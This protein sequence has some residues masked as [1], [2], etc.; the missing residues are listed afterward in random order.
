MLYST[1]SKLSKTVLIFSLV[2]LGKVSIAALSDIKFGQYQIADSQWNTSAC[3]NTTT[4]Q[5]YSK[6]PGTAYKIP[7]WQ[8]QVQWAAG[9]YVKLELS[10]DQNYPY[11]ARQ[12]TSAGVLK[13]TLGTGK[14]VNMGPDYFF[15]VGNDDNTGQLFSGS[16]GMSDTSG[17]TW[18]GTLNPTIAEADAYAAQNYSTTP[19]APGETATPSAPPA[20]TPIYSSGISTTQQTKRNLLLNETSGHQ[21]DISIQGGDNEILIQQ[22]NSGHY[23][24]INIDGNSNNVNI[25]QTTNS[26][27]RH[28]SETVILGNN[29]NLNLIQRDTH[30]NLFVYI[31]GDQ[32]RL[33]VDQKGLGNHYADIQLIGDGHTANVIQEGS[34]NHNATIRLENGGG[35]WNLT[36]GQSGATGKTYSLPHYMS[37]NSLVSG[38]CATL[39]GCNLMINQLD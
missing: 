27:G 37:D 28:Y 4:C 23:A 22:I 32:N 16:S 1:L 29:N 35:A 26:S 15:F 14:I 6:Q 10:G 24:L 21:I 17:V 12:Y 36:L 20:P 30:K 11:I 34:G 13:E 38:V 33:D 31:D 8:G 5:I 39:S 9:D 3:L 2:L 7:W 25:L 18:T 19:L